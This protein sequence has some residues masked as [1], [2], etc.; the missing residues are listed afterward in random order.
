VAVAG[1]VSKTNKLLDIVILVHGRFDLLA[2]CLN[3]IPAAAGEIEYN[4]ILVDNK[5]PE[6]EIARGFYASCDPNYT[7]I[8]NKENLGFPRGCNWGA[9]RKSSPL[10]L[11]LNSDVILEPLAI[12]Y[13]VRALD[14]PTVGVVGAKLLFPSQEQLLDAKLDINPRRGFGTVQHIGIETNIRADF[15]HIFLSWS[16]E[17]P[18]VN[19]MK[20]TYAVTGACFMTR[21]TLWNR[22]GGFFE[23]YGLGTYEDVDFC[24]SA[25]SVGYNVIVEPKAVGTHFVGA[26][27][28]TYKQPMPLM[29]N[30]FT[31]MQRW[32]DKLNYTEFERL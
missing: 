31:F 30:K 29:I 12:D 3:S 24:L 9:K 14:D 8:L 32:G 16:S 10:L 13:M 21:R 2:Q 20:D 15:Y 17:H 25:R 27:S 5:S 6:E 26:S 18:F 23:G 19:R 7:V 22:L 1:L 28:E 11:M 4:V